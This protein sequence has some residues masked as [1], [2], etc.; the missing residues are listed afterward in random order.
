[1]RFAAVEQHYAVNELMILF[2]RKKGKERRSFED[3]ESSGTKISCAHLC[4]PTLERTTL[5]LVFLA[6]R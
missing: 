1:M 4:E 3:G 6:V 2:I 5:G